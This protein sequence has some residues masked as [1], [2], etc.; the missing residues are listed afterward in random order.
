MK[1]LYLVRHEM[2]AYLQ[3]KVVLVS[4]DVNWILWSFSYPNSCKYPLQFTF[5]YL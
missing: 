2:K 4:K 1:A 5:D 3:I